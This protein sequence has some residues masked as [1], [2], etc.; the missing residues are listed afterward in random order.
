MLTKLRYRIFTNIVEHHVCDDRFI[1]MA[2]AM[3]MAAA[4]NPL[5]FITMLEKLLE[6]CG[7][8][9]LKMSDYGVMPTE[10]PKM[11]DNALGPLGGL[12]ACDR[13]RLTKEDCSAIY[14][15]SYK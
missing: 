10:F 11:A 5:D 14:E 12:F 6:D 7:V 13:V 2:K 15:K 3:G 8:A 9:D 1:R 4:K